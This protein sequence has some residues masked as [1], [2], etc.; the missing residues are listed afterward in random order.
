[1]WNLLKN[2]NQHVEIL[3][4]NDAKHTSKSE[5]SKNSQ[6]EVFLTS[7]LC[8]WIVSIFKTGDIKHLWEQIKTKHRSDSFIP[9]L[10]LEMHS[11]SLTPQLT[12]VSEV[13]L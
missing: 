13:H 3:E 4:Y 2:K 11:V 1:M 6:I 8:G 9:S 12:A 10:K 5:P 7:A